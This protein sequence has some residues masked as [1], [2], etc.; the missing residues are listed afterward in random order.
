MWWRNK[1]KRHRISQQLPS[2]EILNV[3]THLSTLL[4]FSFLSGYLLA[5]TQNFWSDLLYCFATINLYAASVVYHYFEK[6]PLKKLLRLFDHASINLLIAASY[7][8]FMLKSNSNVLLTIIWTIA[9]GNILELLYSQTITKLSLV[10]Y[11]IM[12]WAIVFNI[13]PV[14]Y[15]IPTSSFVLLACGGMSY[16]IGTW[17][18]SQDIKRKYFHTIWHAFTAMGSFFHFFAIYTF[19]VP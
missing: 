16:T 6:I 10:K 1:D 13:V 14:Y 15:S 18:F 17:F 9:I 7:T 12:G 11:L 2:E 4:V 19:S 8:P 5:K 3:L